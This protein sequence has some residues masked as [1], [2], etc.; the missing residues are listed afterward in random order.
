MNREIL[1]RGKRVDN[2][3]WVEGFYVAMKTT[4]G[5]KFFIYTSILLDEDIRHRVEVIPETVGQYT[6][7]KDKNGKMIFEGDVVRSFHCEY[8]D[9]Q[10]FDNVLDEEPTG[11]VKFGQYS[12]NTGCSGFGEGT[13]TREIV[14]FYV[15]E[16]FKRIP[17]KFEIIGNIHDSWMAG[18]LHDDNPSGIK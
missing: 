6:G 9:G 4:D 5:I 11:V 12:I 7:L 18:K 15:D 2:G 10:R 1:F 14:G 13:G 17:S 16:Y 3:E 8:R